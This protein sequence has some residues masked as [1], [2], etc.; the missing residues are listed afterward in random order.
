LKSHSNLVVLVVL[1]TER[2]VLTHYVVDG[3]VDLVVYL[4]LHAAPD[5]H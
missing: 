2:E 1:A 3:A 4:A 5:A